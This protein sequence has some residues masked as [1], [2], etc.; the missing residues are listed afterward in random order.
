MSII[1]TNF[2]VKL[3]LLGIIQADMHV[4]VVKMMD[5]VYLLFC[6]VKNNQLMCFCLICHSNAI[7]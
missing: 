7:T 6:Y 1:I 4:I 3:L 2:T 5:P